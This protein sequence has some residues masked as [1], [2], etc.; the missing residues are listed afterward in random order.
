MELTSKCI[1]NNKSHLSHFLEVINKEG[2]RVKAFGVVLKL[3]VC[4]LNILFKIDNLRD[5]RFRN[6]YV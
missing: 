6:I 4:I 1:A 3:E 2:E 5:S